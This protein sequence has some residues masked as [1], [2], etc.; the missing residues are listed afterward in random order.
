MTVAVVLTGQRLLAVRRQDG[1]AAAIL[2]ASTFTVVRVATG[3]SWP[4]DE[5]A[6]GLLGAL[7]AWSL[8]PARAPTARRRR[9]IRRRRVA[10]IA[11]SAVAVLAAV[12]VARTYAAY[13]TAPGDVSIDQ[14]TIEWLRD[15]GL[16]PAVDRAESWWLWRHLPSS[17]AT[18]AALPATA[19]DLGPDAAAGAPPA[20]VAP[21]AP[22]LPGEGMWRVA[23]TDANGVTQ[24]AT[25]TFRPDPAHRSLVA[26]AVW[27]NH[28]TTRLDLIAGTR[29]PGGGPGPAG[30][31]VPA[32]QLAGLLAA[33]NSGYK[34]KDTPGGALVEGRQVRSIVDGIAT[35]GIRADGTADVGVWGR[36]MT[37]ADGYVSLRQN[38]HLMV[39]GGRAVAGLASNAGGRWGTVRNG[40]P[41]WRSGLGVTAGGDLVYV[42]GNNL[43]L[44]V[45]GDALV[46]AGA[47]RGME[48]D[49]HRGMVTF[50]LFTH[51]PAVVGHKLLPDMTRPANRYL[52]ED[53][54]D[55]FTVTAR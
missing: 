54:R 16:G 51:D 1:L 42:A 45:L 31:R 36:D 4:L 41:T 39:D 28:V 11:V 2:L 37:A 6:G 50:N 47:F 14:R 52:H 46:R 40:L 25:T 8:T 9:T 10:A 38:L 49:I 15:I 23:A 30:A 32:A 20:I 12:P 44:G 29:Q 26:G 24:L 19:V 55:F 33:F 48:L 17:T 35:V 21:V 34:M 13:L 53:W 5:I 7:A 22:A 18:I 43:T 27:I 3:V